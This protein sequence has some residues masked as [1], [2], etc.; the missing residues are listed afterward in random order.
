MHF[1]DTGQSEFL[2]FESEIVLD[3]IHQQSPVPRTQI[4]EVMS[5]D[6]RHR[7]RNRNI[8]L[9]WLE[10]LVLQVLKQGQRVPEITESPL[11]ASPNVQVANA[12]GKFTEILQ[13]LIN[14]LVQN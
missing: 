6:Q 10:G 13:Q 9:P 7:E 12:P 14:L 2:R 3:S 1:K 11:K 8:A 4:L 5:K